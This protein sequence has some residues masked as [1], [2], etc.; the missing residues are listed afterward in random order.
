MEDARGN[1]G[2]RSSQRLD[3]AASRTPTSDLAA[4]ATARSRPHN[5]TLAPC[6]W[7][8]RTTARHLINAA[9]PPCQGNRR[10]GVR[11]PQAY[12]PDPE[13]GIVVGGY[14]KRVV[15]PMFAT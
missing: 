14:Q 7:H 15:I 12:P 13:A 3:L 4:R 2:K 1:R 6:G 11:N 8:N 9:D 5:R 10:W